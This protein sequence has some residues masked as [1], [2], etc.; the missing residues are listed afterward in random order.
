[1]GANDAYERALEIDPANAPAK[2]GLQSVSRAMASEGGGNPEEDTMGGLGSMFNDP[3]LFQKLAAN[4]KTAPLL[5]DH[6]FMAKLQAVKKDPKAIGLAMQDQRFLQVM[7]VMLGIDMSFADK[8]P[9][10]ATELG[11]DRREAEEDVPMSDA[12]PSRSS[13]PKEP[14]YVPEV[15]DEEAKAK[16]DAKAKADEEKKLGTEAY[17]KRQFDVAIEH[18]SKAWDLYKDITY[19]TNL[20]A[21]YFEKGDFEKSIEACQ[22]AVEE[23]REM[24]ADFKLIAKSVFP[25]IHLNT[26]TNNFPEHLA[27]LA[28]RTKR[29]AISPEP[30]TTISAL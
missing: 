18:Y 22:K 13:H 27:A 7:S 14:E 20:G 2:S 23:G 25:L 10:G 19:L 12:P 8:M 16:K 3:S 30:S 29:L 4:P 15:E 5:A 11:G 17:K 1:V 21:A 9:T 6:E 26:W 24:L 28:R